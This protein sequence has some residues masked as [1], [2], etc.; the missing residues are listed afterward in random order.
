MGA[1]SPFCGAVKRRRSL[2]QQARNN[3]P[4]SSSACQYV[5]IKNVRRRRLHEE[6]KSC[7]PSLWRRIRLDTATAASP[8][9]FP[10]AFSHVFRSVRNG[11]ALSYS[12]KYEDGDVERVVKRGHIAPFPEE[13]RGHPELAWRRRG[14]RHKGLHLLFFLGLA[15][16]SQLDLAD[17]R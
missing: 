1:A 17:T 12:V 11:Y 5:D 2:F 10:H 8:F 9:P 6:L 14:M 15:N 16:L 13:V 7:L 3:T 4:L